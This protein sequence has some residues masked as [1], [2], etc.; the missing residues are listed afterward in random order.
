M[1]S[2]DG[3]PEQLF[4]TRGASGFRSKRPWDRLRVAL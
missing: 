1:V 3:G 2:Q 4:V